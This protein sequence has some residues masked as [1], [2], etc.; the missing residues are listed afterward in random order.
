MD[1][2]N[3]FSVDAPVEETWRILNDVPRIAPCLPGAKLTEVDGDDYGGVV[4]VKVGPIVA[5]YKGKAIITSVDEPAGR[6]V[7]DAQGRETRGQGSATATITAQ[8]T[9]DGDSRTNVEVTTELTVTGKVASFGRGV[10]ADVSAK[11]MDQFAANLAAEIA[12]PAGESPAE[13]SAAEET[14]APES[15]EPSEPASAATSTAPS[16]AGSPGAGV[17]AINR[18]YGAPDVEDPE[19][20]DL[21]GVA[22]TP[23]LKR[24]LA[25]LAGLVIVVIVVR[26]SRRRRG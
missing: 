25:P 4:K 18:G 9:A 12:L 22:S 13:T 20:I 15:A 14:A 5:Q 3:S 6:I 8:L 26:V 11:L 17:A 24:V 16:P 1:L 19:P 10:M 2:K 23:L 21:L 7:L